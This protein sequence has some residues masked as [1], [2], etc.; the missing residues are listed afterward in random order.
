MADDEP[1]QSEAEEAR[2][3]D[4]EDSAPSAQKDSHPIGWRSALLAFALLSLIYSPYLIAA[5]FVAHGLW[6]LLHHSR[7]VTT[8]V[9]GW[10][11]R[12]CAM[13]A[14]AYAGLFIALGFAG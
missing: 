12:F 1:T 11:P 13:Y 6:D 10:Y 9:P 3:T 7:G 5:G 2:E 14:F 8:S 4:P